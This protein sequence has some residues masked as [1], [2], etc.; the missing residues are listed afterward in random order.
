MGRIDI[1]RKA[2]ATSLEGKNKSWIINEL[3]QNPFDESGVTEVK[4]FIEAVADKRQISVVVEDDVPEGFQRLSDAYTMWA[5]SL[6]VNDPTKAG[7]F[8]EGEKRVIL[9]SESAEVVTTKGK[10]VFEGEERKISRDRTSEG[11]VITA[12]FKGTKADLQDMINGAKRIIPPSHIR[13]VVNGEEIKRGHYVLWAC[14]LPTVHGPELRPTERKT[15]IEIID[16]APG[17]SAWL[18]ECGIPVVE[19]DDK[20]SVNVMQKV[21][22]NR[23]RDNVKPSFLKQLRTLVLN[24]M[25]TQLAPEDFTKP[26]VAEAVNSDDVDTNAVSSYLDAKYGKNRVIADP[27]NPESVSHAQAQG[28]AVIMG[29]SESSATWDKIRSGG[30]ALPA[31]QAFPAKVESM[32]AVIHEDEWTPGMKN[33]A[34]FCQAL[35][36]E[37]IGRSINVS[38][39]NTNN[40]VNACYGSHRITFNI[41]RLGY[42]WFDNGLTQDVLR[43]IIHELGHEYS[44]NHLSSEYHDAL[45]NIGA[46]TALVLLTNPAI[47]GMAG[48]RN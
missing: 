28:F 29:R 18:Y 21:P 32:G 24:H 30:L 33:V 43:L 13:Y 45:C 2:F 12:I 20:W 48:K 6:K 46:K 42:K 14:T 3:V 10:V 26:W 27:S 39:V 11:S 23:D 36:K 44:G 8:N 37:V 4:V 40:S 1:D 16:V 35:A 25:H 41:C 9:Y 5:E 7:R 47:V 17:E 22:L 34:N 38:F 15:E 31:G 19:T